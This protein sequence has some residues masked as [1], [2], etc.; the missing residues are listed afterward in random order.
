MDHESPLFEGAYSPDGT[1][2]IAQT[3]GTTII[4]GGRDVWS[5]RPDRDTVPAPLVV[6][7][8]DEKAISISPDGRWLMYESDETGGR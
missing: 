5:F 3:G 4:P 6:T 8:Y 1:W 2:L 7:D